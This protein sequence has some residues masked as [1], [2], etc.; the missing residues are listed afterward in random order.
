[1]AVD[2]ASDCLEGNFDLAV[3]ITADSD[4]G[5]GSVKSANDARQRLTD[6]SAAG[7]LQPGAGLALYTS[8]P[9]APDWKL[10]VARINHPGRAH[11]GGAPD[12]ICTSLT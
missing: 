9:A 3:V 7:P 5:A 12:G 4:L 2:L 10:S 1:M 6:G 8:N 11:S